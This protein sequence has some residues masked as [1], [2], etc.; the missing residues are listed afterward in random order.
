MDV[1]S[2]LLFN[3]SPARALKDYGGRTEE[4]SRTGF[5]SSTPEGVPLPSYRYG[6]ER[7]DAHTRLFLRRNNPDVVEK[8]GPRRPTGNVA[9]RR[10]I[11]F[12]PLSVKH[13]K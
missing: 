5:D 11:I 13:T 9:S 6:R 4:G 7:G 2:Q 1:Q 12:S 8:S 10:R 3:W